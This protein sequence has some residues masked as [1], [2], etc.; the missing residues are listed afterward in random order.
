M[1][2]FAI[3]ASIN[4][5]VAIALSRNFVYS[6]L[7][8]QFNQK[9]VDLS[10]S[11]FDKEIS[12]LTMFEGMRE[13]KRTSSLSVKVLSICTEI[14]QGLHIRGKYLIVVSLI[15]FSKYFEDFSE[16]SEDFRQTISDMVKTISEDL[17][18]NDEE[19]N[20]CKIFITEKFYKVPQ[21]EK[22]LVVSNMNSFS[23]TKI[24]YIHKDNLNGQFFF[25]NIQQ[26]D[27][28]LF[29]YSGT[30]KVELSNSPIFPGHIYI[31]PKG[32]A[33]K[34]E[35]ITPI[36][37]SEIESGFLRIKT[38]E[39]VSL[40]A[41]NIEFK[42]PKSQN[43]IQKFS[44]ST[45]SGE[46]MGIMGGSGTGK[47]T[48]LKVLNGS[49]QLE[50]GQILINGNN[51]YAETNG[52]K[53]II[54]Y[55]P[56]DDLLIEEL[57]VYQ[58]LFFNAKLCLGDFNDEEIN[59]AVV[60]Y[61]NNLDLFYTKDLLVGSPLNK[62]ISGGQRK[63]LNIALELIREP[64]ILLADE[65][66]TGLSST[67]SENVMQL[68]KDLSLQGKI[69]IIN[70]HK[71]SSEIFKMLDKL[72]IL[73]KGGYPVYLGNPLD[74]FS[75]LKDIANRID[76][77]E[78]ECP[79]C[80]NVQPDE[81]LKVIEA[82]KVNEFGEYTN[83][84]IITP[85]V[86]YEIFRKNLQEEQEPVQEIVNVPASSFK[87]PVHGKQYG[88]YSRRN[89]LSKL[90]D[91]QYSLFAA[92]ISPILAIILGFFTKYISGSSNDELKYMFIDNVNIPA[93]IFMSVIVALFI[94][95]IISAE[96]IIKDSKIL[97]RERFLNLSRRSYL[98]SKVT[99][100]FILSA[101][102][103]LIFVLL[104]NSILEIKGMTLNYWL[105]LFSTACFA[106]MLGLNI[107][108]A[109]KSV[110]AIYITIPF[111]LVPLILLSG[112]IVKYDKMHYSISS[113]KY[114]PVVGDMMASRW[115]YEALMVNQ[116]KNNAF[117]KNFYSIDQESANNSYELNFLIPALFNK[118]DDYERLVNE[119]KSREKIAKI[120]LIIS[121]SVMKLND[122]LIPGLNITTG[123]NPGE[124]LNV[125]SV[126]EFLNNRKARLIQ[127]NKTLI[128][129]K[130]AVF[131]NLKKLGMS[132]DELIS[133]KESYFN[134]S[135]AD[136]V[137]NTN[138][139]SKISESHDDFIRK[140]SPVYQYPLSKTG[141]A[142]FY[143]GI[144]RVGPFEIVTIWFNI[145]ILWIMSLVLYI[146]LLTDLLKKTLNLFSNIG[147]RRRLSKK[148]SFKYGH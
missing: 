123:G 21:K 31:L 57:T 77:A 71:P 101:I 76:A 7:K 47:S 66:T 55:V 138:E 64:I 51:L 95:L 139:M 92:F 144:K 137:L 37:Y 105:V 73:D 22:L 85:S 100:L 42:F 134:R 102:Q 75:Y 136:M 93:Y 38:F 132:N 60:K 8:T 126:S 44:F 1:K 124:T 68:L 72:L 89:F 14:N 2:L 50:N 147:E 52:L 9:I 5:D 113:D 45:K 110:I 62:F 94:G 80:G 29:Y 28:I 133:F 79:Y 86:W 106:V 103:M 131:D 130:D 128:N 96:E 36:Y 119:H 142:Q 10:L 67:D 4:K 41:R 97:E 56:Q 3:L 40:Q 43:G 78:I 23:F 91:K 120:S 108:S 116:F 87:T 32:S 11:V 24:N 35:N 54:G 58:N 49:Y 135:V 117:Q 107:S 48:L 112:V 148:S 122:N 145:M 125:R 69:V 6:Y 82:K 98:N 84:R 127:K 140:D 90:A 88:T 26:S 83:E 59:D 141:R 146:T 143:S 63:R 114:V 99:Y 18:I 39:K 16:S 33:L 104:G 30:G 129:E 25:L 111:I 70:I 15:Q 81:I 34:S 19:Y 74:S 17:R 115:A 12:K 20:N 109:L 118:L 65:P 46:L 13:S 121:N 27:L 61:L 53:G